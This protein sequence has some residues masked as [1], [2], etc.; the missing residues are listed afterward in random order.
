MSI[1]LSK[2][3]RVDLT[4]G[5]P[6]LNK[7]LVGLGWDTNRY[8]GETDFDLDASALL[9][10]DQSKL[11]AE[12][13]FIFYGNLSHSSGCVKH[14][15]DNRTGE[16]DGDDE[17]IEIT[18]N[19]VPS[20]IQSIDISATIY[21]AENRLQNFGMVENA[22]IRLIDAD[23]NEEL[24]RYDLTED[25]STETSLVFAKIYRHNNE[26]KFNAVGSGYKCS[27]G[28]LLV[29]YGIKQEDIIGA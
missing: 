26:W 18:L 2:G 27:L 16:G 22:Y 20:Y 13:D 17:Q 23:T 12:Q 9:L 15:G 6:S 10:N 14:F 11:K 4:K 24:M 25:F 1:N 28:D 5:R 8:E 7:I 19:K 29:T 3:Q 21:D